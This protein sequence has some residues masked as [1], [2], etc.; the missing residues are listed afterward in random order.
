MGLN[1]LR[2]RAALAVTRRSLPGRMTADP[3]AKLGPGLHVAIVGSG[4]PIP[5]TKRGNPCV[6]VF[7]GGRAWLVDAGEGSMETL[8]RMQVDPGRIDGVFMT[9]YHSDHIGGLGSVALQHW[10]GSWKPA[11]E[12]LAVIGPEGVE[13]VV[14]GI[15]L[16][17]SQDAGYRTAHHGERVA[18]SSGGGMRAVSFP[19]PE[20][21]EE[22]VVHD[23]DGLKVTAFRVDHTP[24]DPAIGYR[25]DY[26]GR[27]VVISGDTL[28]VPMTA[29][30]ARGADLLVH[31]A[32]SREL[33]ALVQ[34]AAGAAG[35]ANR[36]QLMIDIEDYHASPQDAADIAREAGV[37]GLVLTHI[38]PPLPLKGLEGIF[39]G[40][41]AE[42][43][44]GPI[45]L[46]SDGDLF[47][48]PAGSTG[49]TPSSMIPRRPGA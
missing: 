13:K 39:L 8:S 47:S 41:C 3:V 49:I 11:T 25:F 28:A 5:D 23:Q 27:S 18:P 16:A 44:P 29:K 37:R 7:A 12:P 2:G 48:L 46:A 19:Q 42:R 33:L 15:N 43:Y 31:D 24:V 9:H 20:G 45:W 6:A 35:H 34:D 30:V 21:E 32:L 36:R 4:S 40:G 1:Q 38:V 22:I 14:E 10:V 17:Y 26:Q